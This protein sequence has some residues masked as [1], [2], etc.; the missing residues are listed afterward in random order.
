[1][2]EKVLQKQREFEVDPFRRNYRIAFFFILFGICAFIRLWHLDL[3][4]MM[5]DELLFTNYTYYDLYKGWSYRY[6]AILHGPLML[7]IQNLTFHLFGA[8]DYTVRL[9][10][11]LLGVFSFLWLWKLRYWLGEFGTWFVLA[12]YAIAPGISFFNRFFHQDSLYLFNSLWIIASLANWWR[13]RDGRWAASAILA[14][15]ALFNTKASAVFLYFSIITFVLIVVLYDLASYPLE[16]KSMRLNGVF[17]K[18][19]KMPG[20]V[21]IALAGLL[22]VTLVLT[23]VFEGMTLSLTAHERRQLGHDWVLRDVRSIPIL[24]EW[25]EV[26]D[27]SDAGAV[28]NAGFWRLFYP[29]LAIVLL[30]GSFLLK[31]FTEQRIGRNEFLSN[32]WVRLYKARWYVIGAIALSVSF[33]L[34]I[35]TTFFKHKIG[36]FNIYRET[37]AYWGGQH[38]IG[39][40]KG[41]FHQHM[42][43][44]VLYEMPAVIIILAAWFAGLFRV[45]WTRSTGIA[46]LLMVLAV[47]AFH[48][49]LFSNLYLRY[50][51][52]L[53]PV[54]AGINYLKNIFIA[55]VLIGLITICFPKSGRVLAPLSFLGLVVYSV[56]FIASDRWQLA[57]RGL[58]YKNGQPVEMM[59]RHVNLL[60]YMEIQFNFD[61]ATSIAM[62]LTL[63]FF[64]TL[65][66]WTLLQQGRRFHAFAVWWFVTMLGSASY[67]REAV[68]Q[69]GIHAM[70][71]AIVLAGLYVQRFFETK[72]RPMMRKFAFAAIGLFLLLNV[73]AVINLNFRNPSDPRERMVYGPSNVDVKAHMNFIRDYTKIAGLRMDNGRPSVFTNYNNPKLHK[74]VDVYIKRIDQVTWPAKWYLRDINYEEGSDPTKAIENDYAFIFI[75]VE[76]EDSFPALKEKY[77]MVRGRGTSF[78]TPDM[79]APKSLFGIWKE[80]IPGHYLDN[81]ANASKAFDSK[82]NWKR[83]WRYLILRETFEGTGR[84]VPSVSSFEYIFCYRKDLY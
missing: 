9:G 43:N 18:I 51:G 63:I 31:L 17:E 3:K 7:H 20:A 8:S 78:W 15:T 55:G 35:Y 23:Q 57:V 84:T 16:G 47:G 21:W 11:A 10:A 62:V 34:I 67:A 60:D 32:V 71:P 73:K 41:P 69:V 56:V 36:F 77:N 4:T 53:E 50:P 54:P 49:L 75:S 83:I 28:A 14:I 2:T 25:Y 40:I 48:K 65:Y 24:L 13:T 61:G 82:Q 68:P 27:G 1:M 42:L 52:I 5:H 58:V 38:E 26:L 12:F 19:P 37:W 45:K 59:E 46:F 44:L 81:T 33:Y 79:I 22:A 70:M 80:W 30:A 74:D 29:G 64:A 39:R 6:Q 76:D 66:T 72:P